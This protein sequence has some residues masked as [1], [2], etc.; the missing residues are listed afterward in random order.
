M[1]DQAFST[2]LTDRSKFDGLES[3]TLF[4]TSV[5]RHPASAVVASN[6]IRQSAPP[7]D[8]E[9]TPTPPQNHE[10]PHLKAPQENQPS[11]NSHLTPTIQSQSD[12]EEST[13]DSASIEPE[14]EVI[15]GLV[16]AVSEPASKSE[17]NTEYSATTTFNGKAAQSSQPTSQPSSNVSS[18]SSKLGEESVREVILQ[19]VDGTLGIVLLTSEKDPTS[20]VYI[21]E[22]RSAVALSAG[23]R[24]GDRIVRIKN[25]AVE[26]LHYNEVKKMLAGTGPEPFAVHVMFDQNMHGLVQSDFT[27]A[28]SSGLNSSVCIIDLVRS[29]MH[30]SILSLLASL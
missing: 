9:T 2:Q 27:R 30:I 1:P 14:D 8:H 7:Q 29:T 11:V 28:N 19:R 4:A 12:D 16:C 15:D 6:E 10:S 26:G 22:I 18:H 20:A 24:V 3:T 25:Y 21:K 13:G 5:P 23:L 17:T